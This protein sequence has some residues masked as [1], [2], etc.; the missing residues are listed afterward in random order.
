MTNAFSL[1]ALWKVFYVKLF[2]LISWMYVTICDRH[3]INYLKYLK[4]VFSR[5]S[6]ILRLRK[7]EHENGRTVSDTSIMS[8]TSIVS[9]FSRQNWTHGL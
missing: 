8:M 7:K 3:S 6:F 9:P 1:S 2:F 5:I 4:H